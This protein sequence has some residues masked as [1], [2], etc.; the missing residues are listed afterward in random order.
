VIDLFHQLTGAIAAAMVGI[1]SVFLVIRGRGHHERDALER[2]G[3]TREI[4]IRKSLG[5]RRSDILMQFLVEAGV[6][7]A[8][9]G[10]M[11]CSLPIS[12]RWWWE[13]PRRADGR[14]VFCRDDR[15]DG[16]DSRGHLFRSLSGAQ[17]VA[18]GSHCGAAHG[19]LRP[20]MKMRIRLGLGENTLMGAGHAAA[21]QAPLA[22]DGAG[23]GDRVTTLILVASILVGLDRDIRGFLSDFG[24][25]TLWIFKIKQ[26]FTGELTQEER[27]RKPLSLEDA[28]ASKNPARRCAP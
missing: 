25:D 13:P 12:S 1:V 8:L 21:E 11:G 16:F 3:R 26:G 14:A 5:A 7:A 10:A 23:G 24:T 19:G 28:L 18:P 27:M 4:G 20:S 6:M 22:A 17:S 15:A 9:G 2:H